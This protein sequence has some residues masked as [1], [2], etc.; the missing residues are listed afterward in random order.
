MN[1]IWK[2]KGTDND[3]KVTLQT[4]KKISNLIATNK[5]LVETT[6][7]DT[8]KLTSMFTYCQIN[9]KDFTLKVS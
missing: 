3:Y 2:F 4:D 1:F 5:N 8:V 6:K 9:A 7:K